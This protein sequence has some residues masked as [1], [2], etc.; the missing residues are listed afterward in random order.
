MDVRAYPR[1]ETQIGVRFLLNGEPGE[2]VSPNISAGGI[3]VA[4]DAEVA[5]GDSAIIHL[6][7][8]A[9]LEGT[10]VRVFDG[11]F[12]VEFAMNDAK[13]DRMMAAVDALE[14][15]DAPARELHLDRRISERVGVSNLETVCTTA[16]GDVKCKLIDVSVYGVAFETN[17]PLRVGDRVRLGRSFGRVVRKD[18]AV[19]GVDLESAQAADNPLLAALF[20]EEGV[21]TV[22]DVDIPAGWSGV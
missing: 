18:G 15:L 6:N 20:G 2:G 19:Y 21:P 16:R 22:V 17:A 12:A 3:A 7:G 13:R 10:V 8:S 4:S 9:R 11:G 1:V 5:V 14:V